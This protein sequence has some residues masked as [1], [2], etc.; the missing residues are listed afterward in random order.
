[1]TCAQCRELLDAYIDG[2]LARTLRTQDAPRDD[3]DLAAVEPKVLRFL[4][5]R[6]TKAAKTAA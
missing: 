1:M 4:E 3:D 6:L 2:D 5:R